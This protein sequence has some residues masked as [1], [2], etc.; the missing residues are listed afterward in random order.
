[1]AG[2]LARAPVTE[3]VTEWVPVVA[4]T[5]PGV[6]AESAGSAGSAVCLCSSL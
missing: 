1:M 2:T 5:V 4:V 3:K 6:T